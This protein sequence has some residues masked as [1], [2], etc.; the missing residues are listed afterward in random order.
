MRSFS[1]YNSVNRFNR[2]FTKILSWR[3]LFME[4][5]I[6]DLLDHPK[7]LETRGHL[8]HSI[9]KHDH[10]LRSV[11]YSSRFARILH[12]DERVCV[13]AALIHDIDS[14]FG[15]LTNHG[16]IAARWAAEQGEPAEVCAAITSHMYPFGPAPISREAWVLVLADKAASLGDFKQ[17]VRG[18]LDGSSLATRRR[19]R[20]S[21][22]H[23][24]A[25]PPLSRRLRRRVR[26]ATER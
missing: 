2:P 21:D 20:A 17:F 7:V 9:P 14:R 15:T 6:T 8:H 22:P 19:L 12:A 25:R 10:L 4:H 1:Q 11:K 16:E 24:C 5:F 13:R 26:T 18:L 23:Y 3:Q